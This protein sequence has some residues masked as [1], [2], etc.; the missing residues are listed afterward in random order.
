MY[1]IV[2]AGFEA[3]IRAKTVWFIF[4][5]TEGIEP[6]TVAETYTQM[7]AVAA[8]P[9]AHLVTASNGVWAFEW[10]VPKG[11]RNVTIGGTD[12][13]VAPTW[14]LAGVAGSATITGNHD[15]WHVT[16]NGQPGYVID[17]AYWRELPGT[18]VADV[19]LSA[20]TQT[21]AQTN[22]ELWNTTTGALLSRK[23]V[24]NTD[25]RIT[26]HLHGDLPSISPQPLFRGYGLWRITPLPAPP[27][28]EL[29]IRVWTPGGKDH[30]S[31]Y[32]A[33]IRR[34]AGPS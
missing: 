30:V 1:P 33:G 32:D 12:S 11:T 20:T 22:V 6:A 2:S 4:A 21:N 23:V 34:I 3:P 14:A 5:P 7:A 19:S 13:S 8:Y 18:Y 29:E 24:G 16:S 27:G 17:H 10:H 25:G 9:H 26:V 15:D 28:D 31:V